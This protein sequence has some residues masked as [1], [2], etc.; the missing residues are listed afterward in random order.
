[1]AEERREQIKSG[2]I[3]FIQGDLPRDL[4]FLQSGSLEILSASA[5]YDGLD[6][7]IIISKSKR[8][9]ILKGKTLIPGLSEN[10]TGPYKK[11]VRAL[12]D[13]YITKYSLGG[14]G[15]KGVI[16]SD[17]AQAATVLRQ[18]YNRLNLTI[19]ET[20]KFARLHQNISMVGDNLALIYKELSQSN[21]ADDLDS[22]A[23]MLHNNY[24][25]SG[26]Q[27]PEQFTAKFLVTDN[28]RYLSRRYEVPGESPEL[29]FKQEY[30]SFLKKILKLQPAIFNAMIKANSEIAEDMYGFLSGLYMKSLTRI[31]TIYDLLN[32]ELAKI[33]GQDSSWSSYLVDNN[34]FD[35]WISSNRL[36]ADFVKNFLSLLVK[37]NSIYEDITGVKLTADYPGIKMIHQYY[38]TSRTAAVEAESTG[39]VKGQEAAS[40][41]I[42]SGLKRS[43]NQIFEFSLV[44]KDFQN[45]FL[46]LLNDFKTSKNPFNTESD[47]RKMR[48]HLATMY[49]DMYKQSYIRSKTESNIPKPVQLMLSFGYIDEDLV[50]PEQLVEL[51]DLLRLKEKESSYSILHEGEFLSLIYAGQESPS[52]TEMGL[53]YE[54]HLREMEKHRGKKKEDPTAGLDDNVKMTMYEI[55][56]RLASTSA[57]CSGSTATAFPILTSLAVKGSLKGI[58]SSK[59]KIE[60]T[61]DKIRNVDFSVFYRETVL[62]MG[63]ARE[64]IQEEVLPYVV[65][66]PIF[67]TRTLLWQELSGTNK[68]SK[69]RIVIP[70]FFMGDFEKNLAH[71]LACFRWELSRTMKGAMWADPIEGGVTGEYFDYVNTYKKNSKLSAEAKEKIK[72]KFR[73]L[74]TNRD[75]F[76]DDYL[77]WV[78]FEKDGIMK[79]NA[80]VREMFFKHIPFR[81]DIRDRLDNMPAFN[82]YANRY[83]NVSAKTITSYERRFKKYQDETGKHPGEMEHFFEFLKM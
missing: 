63:D 44:D 29:L 67:G 38:T 72:D 62:K 58:Y 49:W 82:H 18:L 76:A 43:L 31:E 56:Q 48:R 79:L 26:G 81:K 13:S 24:S 1:M 8:L 37:I 52:I 10:L 33:F 30:C 20:T 40:A 41:E 32:R 2:E 14:D 83:K 6:R 77:M 70:A 60:K 11:S 25:S 35:E 15:F 4:M 53:T 51:N 71:T 59:E 78:L 47:G 54:A 9:S 80:V 42:V 3:L 16:S 61:L 55:E 46:K 19:N 57:V 23:E 28:S 75:R 74:R 22:K 12:E 68:R 17:Q 45:R 64:I 5:E 65:V 69:G 50:E 27:I 66:L 21:A 73:G 34:G 7:E 36:N 39:A